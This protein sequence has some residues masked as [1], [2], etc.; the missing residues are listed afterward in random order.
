MANVQEIANWESGIYQIETTDPVLGGPNG[1]ANAQAK[2]LA[3]RTAF[4]KQQI[5]QLNSGQ[6]APAWIASIN[7]VQSELQKLDI[8]QSVRCASVGDISY[9]GG[10]QTIDGVSLSIGDRILVKDQVTATQ[11]GIYVVAAT[12]WPRS[13]DADNG[14][15]LTSGARIA[16][17]EGSIN[18]GKVWYLANAGAIN[19]GSTNLIFF[20]EKPYA[21]QSTP[22][23]VSLAS[24]S[25]A[26]SGV[27]DK[28]AVTPK[29]AL[30]VALTAYPVGAPIPWPSTVVP[31]GYAKFNGGSFNVSA[32]PR[33]AALY[34]SGVLPDM[35]GLHI[36]GLDDGKGHDP[37][38]SILSYQAD[39]NKAHSHRFENTF[40]A[41]I[42]PFDTIDGRVGTITPQAIANS[43]AHV[44]TV[45]AVGGAYFSTVIASQGGAEVTVKSMAFLWITRLG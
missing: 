43:A 37:G 26:V 5:E 8:K 10:V 15:K 14:S 20:D 32:N 1:I 9:L 31:A 23:F 45:P 40:G 35:R 28:K 36:R 34:P 13:A 6:I 42:G 11:N 44:A 19:V 3:N 27:D 12:A 21:T 4:L 38:R 25:E 29:G 33:L 24:S 18:A 17:E 16:V 41:P 39:Q 30:E 22:G 2:A 7:Y